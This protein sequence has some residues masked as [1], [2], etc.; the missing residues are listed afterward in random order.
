LKERFSKAV[1]VDAASLAKAGAY[2]WLEWG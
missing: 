1:D 2:N